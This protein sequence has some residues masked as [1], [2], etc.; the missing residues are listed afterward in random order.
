MRMTNREQEILKLLRNNPMISQ[1]ELA[2]ALHITRSSVGVHITNLM[3]KGFILGKGYILQR[4]RYVCV[5]GGSNVD[6]QGSPRGKLIARD[7]NIGSVKISL[8]GVGRNI[9]ENLVRL[10]VDTRLI[11]VVGDDAYGQKILEEA[12]LIGLNMQDT[13]ILNGAASSVYLCILD[14]TGDMVL[15]INSMDI[16]ERMTVD[17]IKSKKHVIEN[18]ELCI[19]DTNIP[20]DVLEYVLSTMKNAVFFLDAVSTAKAK[21]VRDLIGYFHTIKP[22]RIEAEVLSGISIH[23]EADLKQAADIFHKKGVRQVFI[24]LGEEGVF[25]ST[26]AETSHI[27]PPG[28]KIVNATGAGDAFLAAL[29]LGYLRGMDARQS[30]RLACAASAIA[31]SHE[32]TINPTM[33]LESLFD[34]AKELEI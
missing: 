22:N 11:S 21:K 24:S 9:A 20:A 30:A 16:Y 1:N 10:G 33:S 28:V 3:K 27:R 12:R 8:G 31:M 18:A 13:L 2:N 25:C 34:K 14:D 6:I 5:I 17:F 29:A 4:E 19:L 15:A 7:S 26:P 32:N 23:K